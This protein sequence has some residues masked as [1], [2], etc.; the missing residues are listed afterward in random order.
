MSHKSMLLIAEIKAARC[1]ARRGN[2]RM[3]AAY[4]RLQG[5]SLQT[6]LRVTKGD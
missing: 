6:A 5:W 3:A 2:P 4:L 1:L